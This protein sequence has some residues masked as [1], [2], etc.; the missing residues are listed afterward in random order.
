MDSIGLADGCSPAMPCTFCL[1]NLMACAC[2]WTALICFFSAFLR[3]YVPGPPAWATVLLRWVCPSRHRPPPLAGF[4][5][6]R[7][8]PN[9]LADLFQIAVFHI[10]CMLSSGRGDAPSNGCC[11][12]KCSFLCV[13]ASLG[14]ILIV[15]G[16]RE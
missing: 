2:F 5:V 3:S 7:L 4:H 12:S 10:P 15:H 11:T 9:C 8:A 6:R 13:F 1:G 14:W 16:I